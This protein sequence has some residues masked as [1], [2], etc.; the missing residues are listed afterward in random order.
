M[1]RKP[2]LILFYS[3]ALGIAMSGA[4]AQAQLPL[5]S[6]GDAI[7]AIDL[8]EAGSASSYPMGEPP[9]AV[10]DGDT[11]T[12]YLNFAGPNSGLIVTPQLAGTTIQSLQLTTANDAEARDPASFELYGTNDP[13]TSADNSSGLA[14]NWTLIAASPVSLPPER[15]TLGPVVSF[16]NSTAY[17]SYRLM[18]PTLKGGPLMQVA[19]L[20]LF[21]SSDGSGAN[22]LAP[23]DF[24]IAVHNAPNSRYPT[25]EPP[26]AAIDNDP[27]TKYLNFGQ[28]NSGFVVT[29]AVGPSVVKWFQITT[30]ND[31][32]ER[33]PATW[34]LYGTNDPITSDDNSRA[35]NE[36]WTLI[37]S[38]SISLPDERDTAGPLVAVD[39]SLEF[40]AYRF[41]VTGVKDAET[42]NSVQFAEIQFFAIPEPSSM[43]LLLISGVS[44]VLWGSRRRQA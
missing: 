33:D 44:I 35:M 18:F 17:D 19:D 11:A 13:I 7:L 39:N 32:P 43:L 22:I 9:S 2:G 34:E 30:A 31:S 40:G 28:V 10:L 26:S 1:I 42:A 6:P 36:N 4:P 41:V 29:P 20:G 12:K 38:G 15:E 3:L 14:E 24:T 25:N 23:G 37:D 5:L 8:D 16:S 21:E 27:A